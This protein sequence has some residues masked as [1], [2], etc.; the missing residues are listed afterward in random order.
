LIRGPFINVTLMNGPLI[1][2]VS[3]SRTDRRRWTMVNW[4]VVPCTSVHLRRS[5]CSWRPGR[6][7]RWSV[8]PSSWR[9]S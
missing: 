5:F 1:N 2:L 4:A 8:S 6:S 9:V 7:R 3:S